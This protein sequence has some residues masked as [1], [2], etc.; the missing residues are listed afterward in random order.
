MKNPQIL[1]NTPQDSRTDYRPCIKKQNAVF[2]QKTEL[3]DT[4]KS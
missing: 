2:E 1:W 4:S 3:Q